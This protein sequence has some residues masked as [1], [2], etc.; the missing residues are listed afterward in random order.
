MQNLNYIFQ[1]VMNDI[2]AIGFP[3]SSELDK[4]IFIDKQTYDRVGA[5]YRYL[6]PL[7]YEIHLSEKTLRASK[8]QIKNVLAH[9]LLHA[10]PFTIEHNACWQYYSNLM[11]NKFNYNIQIKYTWDQILNDK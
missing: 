8:R 5:C 3:I 1:E 11:N 2:D 4:H 7:K 10:N 6:F 9:E